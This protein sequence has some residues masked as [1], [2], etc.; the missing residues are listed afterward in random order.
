MLDLTCASDNIKQTL[1]PSKWRGKQKFNGFFFAINIKKIRPSAFNRTH[2]FD[3][4][5]VMVEQEDTLMASMAARRIYPKICKHLFVYHYKSVTVKASRSTSRIRNNLQFYHPEISRKQWIVGSSSIVLNYSND[6]QFKLDNSDAT[7]DD[8]PATTYIYPDASIH[9]GHHSHIMEMSRVYPS[10]KEFISKVVAF[11]L[12]SYVTEDAFLLVGRNRAW[13]GNYHVVCNNNSFSS[14]RAGKRHDSKSK[15]F[16]CG[17]KVHQD[18]FA[19][20]QFSH[21]LQNLFEVRIK[22]LFEQSSRDWYDLS[23]VDLMINMADSY[24]LNKV[25]NAKPNVVKVA[26]IGDMFDS[27]LESRYIGNYDLLLVPSFWSKHY[28]SRLN[29]LPVR[30]LVKCPFHLLSA[31]RQANVLVEVFPPVASM[32]FTEFALKEVEMDYIIDMQDAWMESLSAKLPGLLGSSSWGVLRRQCKRVFV[33]RYA[34]KGTEQSRVLLRG[35]LESYLRSTRVVISRVKPTALFNGLDPFLLGALAS[36]ARVLLYQ[37]VSQPLYDYSKHLVTSYNMSSLVNQIRQYMSLPPNSTTERDKSEYRMLRQE[38]LEDNSFFSRAALLSRA[39]KTNGLMTMNSLSVPVQES[40]V[41]ILER[42][43]ICVGISTGPYPYDPRNEYALRN[44]IY[45]LIE[46]FVRSNH[47]DDFRL[48]VYVLQPMYPSP[49][50][51]ESLKNVVDDGEKIAS[52]LGREETVSLSLYWNEFYVRYDEKRA[53]KNSRVQFDDLD[54]FIQ[55][56]RIEA[57]CDWCM[58]SQMT[59]TQNLHFMNT[60]L[61]FLAAGNS[62][63]IAWDFASRDPRY[64]FNPKSEVVTAAPTPDRISPFT[65]LF[66]I[67]DTAHGDVRFVQFENFRTNFVRSRAFEFSFVGALLRHISPDRIVY[68]HSNSNPLMNHTTP[69]VREKKGLMLWNWH[70]M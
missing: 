55:Y 52:R 65:I 63:L 5:N 8:E 60:V 53:T 19:T 64:R 41:D 42:K 26:W 30:C 7:E 21:S 12:P 24:Q 29:A 27:W 18:I 47:S 61:P 16:C 32:D 28:I 44:K 49:S 14:A 58:F 10:N 22:Y 23:N 48:S 56:L 9:H 40:A 4:N 51:V 35:S 50:Q 25:Y 15:K 31:Q 43:N 34:M 2:L 6:T 20:V 33:W 3:P 45:T 68:I 59:W 17:S 37:P 1:I 38:I 70:L 57:Q 54:D 36:G 67:V 13:T 39:L 66:R 46:Q 69:P 11:V 62:S